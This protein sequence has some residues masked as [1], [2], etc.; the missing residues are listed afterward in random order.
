MEKHLIMS[1]FFSISLFTYFFQSFDPLLTFLQQTFCVTC[2]FV[3][4]GLCEEQ[5]LVL[6]PY[7]IF[8]FAFMSWQ[9]KQKENMGLD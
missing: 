2:G 1:F 6:F 4:N 8:I 5:F 7:L 9:Q 3:K